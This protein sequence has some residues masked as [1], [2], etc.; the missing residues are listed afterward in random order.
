MTTGSMIF[1]GVCLAAA[2]IFAMAVAH[3]INQTHNP[4]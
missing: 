4:H 1:L 2:A 3:G